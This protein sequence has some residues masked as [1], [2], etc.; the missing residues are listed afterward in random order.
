MNRLAYV[1]IV[2]TEETEGLLTCGHQFLDSFFPRPL[3]I[4]CRHVPAVVGDAIKRDFRGFGIFHRIAAE[5]R[6]KVGNVEPVAV[7]LSH[8]QAAL[9]IVVHRIVKPNESLALDLR[10]YPFHIV[11]IYHIDHAISSPHDTHLWIHLRAKRREVIS[12]TP[13]LVILRRTYNEWLHVLV[14]ADKIVGQVVH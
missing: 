14:F 9:T 7:S 11:A 13:V 10:V 6:H 4:I 1:D 2:L 5:T 8:E 12:A 3:G